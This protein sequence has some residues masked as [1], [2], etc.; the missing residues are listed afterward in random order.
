MGLAVGQNGVVD[1]ALQVGQVSDSDPSG[2]AQSASGHLAGAETIKEFQI[3]T[4][5]HSPEY[6]SQAGAIVSGVTKS[7]TNTLHG[8]LFEFLRNDALDSA[9]REEN[10][11][12]GK[13]P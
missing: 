2:N 13:A 9:K 12:G 1:F 3:I 8:S 10:K 7:G 6:G 11:G 5:N 4:N